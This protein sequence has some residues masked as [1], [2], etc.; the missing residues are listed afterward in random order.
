MPEYT[1]H[2]GDEGKKRLDILANTIE[3][4][5]ARFLEMAR[6][7]AG[8]RCLDLAC[9]GGNVALILAKYVGAQGQVTGLDMDERKIQ[10]AT[11]SA[12]FNGIKNVSFKTLNAYDLMDQG[13]Y[14]L[15]YSRFLLCHLSKP[16]IVLQNLWRALKPDG[17]LLVEDTDFT[18]HFSHPSSKDFNRYVSLYQRLLNKR[19]ADANIGQKLV[20]LFKKAGFVDI[21]FQLSQPVHI[22]GA[23]KLMAEIT[24]EGISKALIEEGLITAEEA[25]KIHSGLVDFRKRSDSLISLP[26]IFQVNGR[27]P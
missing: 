22:E 4:G 25:G 14:D 24:F 27:R 15:A 17:I 11:E 18:G 5:T 2:G 23:G 20:G 7:K 19:G 12:A 9:G 13:V 21:E 10:L 3:P 6:I 8:M 1:I 26:R 16:Q